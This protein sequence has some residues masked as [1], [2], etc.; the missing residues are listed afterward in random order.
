MTS[1]PPEATILSVRDGEPVAEEVLAHLDECAAC[2]RA[3]KEARDRAG[4]IENAL[5]ALRVP[6]QAPGEAAD[7]PARGGRQ[8]MAAPRPQTSRGAFRI[9]WWLGR[10]ALLLLIVAG[11]LS[12]LP[13]PFAGWIPRI[14]S[15]APAPEAPLAAAPELPGQVGGRMAVSSGPVAIRLES[16]PTGT[17]VDVRRAADGSVGVLAAAGSEFSYGEREVRASIAA[18][19]VTVELP[20]GLVP[21]TLIV[22]GGV[23]L[24]LD[25]AGMEVTG[26]STTPGEA[27]L[28]TFRVQD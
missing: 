27:S 18:G 8:G 6:A 10:A 22:N 14:F 25:A 12:A 1:H 5:A 4:T 24:V 15:G 16:V 2:A 28:A 19:P 3:L 13:G 26:P 17:V 11:A 9:P 7:G 23:Y 21:A 20:E